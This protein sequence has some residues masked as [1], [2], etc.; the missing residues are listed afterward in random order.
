MTKNSIFKITT[1]IIVLL[2]FAVIYGCDKQCD[3]QAPQPLS[4]NFQWINS[5]NIDIF[6]NKKEDKD[7]ETFVV[8]KFD[9]VRH[10]LNFRAFK[11]STV[12]Y[13]DA[14]PPL[15]TI[16]ENKLD[17][18]YLKIKETDID[19]IVAKIAKIEDPCYSTIYHFTELSY[20]GKSLSGTDSLY[21]IK[22]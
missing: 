8:T 22:K 20:N 7:I 5:S 18:F 4:L 9:T 13:F 11:D 19:T 10:T 3:K 1:R 16:L 14:L 15:R 6:N 2:I 21:I 17:T 12:F